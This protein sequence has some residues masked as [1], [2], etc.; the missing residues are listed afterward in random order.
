M[1]RIGILA[2]ID[3][4]DLRL[5]PGKERLCI[6][7]DY[8]FAISQADGIPLVLPYIKEIHAIERQLDAVD[9][10]LLSGGHDV[11]P[12]HYG[13]EPIQQLGE[14]CAERDDYEIKAIRIALERNQP[15]FAICRGLQIL[16]V[17]L[18]GSLFQDIPH[19]TNSGQQH[20]QQAKGHVAS[21]A[22]DLVPSTLLHQIAGE[23]TVMVNSFHHQ[24]I[25]KLAPELIVNARARDGMIEGVEMM[26]SPWVLGVQ[27][28]PERM[29]AH[30][31]VMQRLFKAFITAAG[32]P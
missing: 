2:H 26:G 15:I 3:T 21:H 24:A 11:H 20:S 30:H 28:H 12:H 4:G 27:W 31:P 19:Q 6:N 8:V 14:V 17:A 1:V 22:V 7:Q 18:G 5:D 16:N 29:V 32:R 13:E 23:P 25:N 9:A 10:I